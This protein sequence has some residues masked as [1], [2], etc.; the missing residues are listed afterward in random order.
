[1]NVWLGLLSSKLIGPIV[2]D[3]NLTSGT[4]TLFLRHEL[5]CLLEWTVFIVSGQMYFQCDGA[6]S[7]CAQHVKQYLQECFLDHWLGHGGPLAWPL[8]SPDLTLLNYYLWG[9]MK[10]FMYEVRV[11]LGARLCHRVF[12]AAAEHRCNC[13]DYMA[14][15][16]QSMLV[17]AEKA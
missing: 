12:A 5:P 11:D 1:M 16:T 10:T 6:E 14:S 15:T 8:K 17:H 13:H 9:H 3:N 4:Y 2:F 7:L